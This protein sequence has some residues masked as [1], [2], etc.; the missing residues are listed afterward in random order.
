MLKRLLYIVAL[1]TISHTVAIAQ[2]GLNYWFDT[3]TTLQGRATWYGGKPDIKKG[4]KK[5]IS[6]GDAIKNSD[7]E[8]EQKSL[9]IGNGSIGAN[10]MGSVAAERLT[11]N[12]KT[13]WRGGPNTS[14][15]ARYYWD[16]NKA[17]AHIITDIRKAFIDNDHKRAEQLTRN[18]FNSVVPY[19]TEAEEP[20]RF[21]SF[22]TAGE[23]YIETGLSEVGMKNYRRSLSL[24]SALATVSFDKDG[25]HYRREFFVSYPANV[26]VM[27]FSASKKGRQNLVLSYAKNPVSEGTMHTN[28]NDAL[29]WNARLDNNSMQYCI[30][31]KAIP[32]G[33]TINN[34]N[35]KITVTGA[36]E[37]VFIISADTDYKPN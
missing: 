10:V 19:E 9:P 35:E 27:R 20:F 2:Q 37:V 26:L 32:K 16:V 33:G 36:D 3:P 28:G 31:M 13:L 1:M 24:D 17:S 23:L 11:L 18:N 4:D 15:G 8:W 7:E 6:A 12:E 22:T 30:C 34:K 29:L 25:I 21:G 5:P 14:K